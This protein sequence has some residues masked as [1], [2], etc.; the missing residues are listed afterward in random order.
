M[1]P[2]VN[3]VVPLYNEESVFEQLI[4]RLVGLMESSKLTIEVILINDGSKD[5]TPEL[6][7]ALSEKDHRFHYPRFG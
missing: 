3:L 4:D 7:Q 6:M 2:Q 1:N 5:R